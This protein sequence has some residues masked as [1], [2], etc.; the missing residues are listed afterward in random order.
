MSAIGC[1]VNL[2]KGEIRESGIRTDGR[3]FIGVDIDNN[4]LPR[5]FIGERLQR[6]DFDS[7]EILR[8]ESSVK[9]FGHT[10][11]SMLHS[12]RGKSWQYT[13]L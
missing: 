12:M 3:K 13:S 10:A 8:V 1:V 9:G 4:V 7:R 5:V 11:L 6:G 2:D